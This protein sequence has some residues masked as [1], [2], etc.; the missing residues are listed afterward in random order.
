M[1]YPHIRMTNTAEPLER[2]DAHYINKPTHKKETHIMTIST[3]TNTISL[4]ELTYR[5]GKPTN[6]L[7]LT[8]PE[9]H[10]GYKFADGRER[11]FSDMNMILSKET[12]LS[13][14][15]PSV[16]KM[17]ETIDWEQ[18]VEMN[19]ALI[20]EA[21]SRDAG[22]DEAHVAREIGCH[23]LDILAELEELD[24]PLDTKL[25]EHLPNLLCSIWALSDAFCLEFD[26]KLWERGDEPH[27]F[28]RDMNIDIYGVGGR[29]LASRLWDHIEISH[30]R[31]VQARHADRIAK[32]Q[33]RDA[34]KKKAA[35]KA[36]KKARKR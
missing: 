33:K 29:N 20:R 24:A 7:D 3:P 34:A 36:A 8:V 23:T 30:E 19:R 17:R 6:I 31:G 25:A 35:T 1:L 9:Q 26:G 13:Y 15:F 14:T 10:D 27:R 32:N 22:A 12:G 4:S 5:T 16:F 11:T 21:L 18:G 28:F 2:I